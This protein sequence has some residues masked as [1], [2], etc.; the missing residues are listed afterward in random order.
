MP[1]PSPGKP[2][3]PPKSPTD[4]QPTDFFVG[5]V[6]RG[7]SG[8]CYGVETDDGKVYAVYSTEA[9]NLAVG[10]T[11]RVYHKPLLLKIYCGEGEHVS[12][13]RVDVIR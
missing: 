12:G 10:T 5:R 1:T 8:P 3:G 13:V 4:P 6:V 11:V 2:S 9:G 7:G